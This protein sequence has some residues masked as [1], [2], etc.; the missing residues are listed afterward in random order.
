M[1]YLIRQGNAIKL[2]G[3]SDL[4]VEN[5]AALH[6][7]RPRSER[8]SASL[9]D[10]TETGGDATEDNIISG[11][12]MRAIQGATFGFGD[13]ALGS[14]LGVLT[15]EGAAGGIDSYRERLR[16][17]PAG[18]KLGL[19]AEVTGGFLTGGALVRGAAA[20]GAGS[21]TA[22]ST[23]GQRA[24][25]VGAQGALGGALGGAG[26]NEGTISERTKSALLGAG[27][28][29]VLGAGLVGAGRVAGSLLRAPTRAVLDRFK[30][31]QSALPGLGSSRDHARRLVLETIESEGLAVGQMRQAAAMLRTQGVAPTLADVGGEGTLQLMSE[32]LATRSPEKQKLAEA[33]LGR[34]SEQ[35]ARLSGD[36]FRR[37][38]RS[39]K[40]GLG[41]A[42]DTVDELA[43][44]R[45]ASAAPLYEQAYQ[46][47][48]PV[49]ERMQAIITKNPKFR[50]AWEEGMRIAKTEELAGVGHGLEI[51]QLP[52]GSLHEAARQKLIDI[53]ASEEAIT[54]TLAQLPND[55]PAQ[56]PVRGLDYMKRGIDVIINRG[57]RAN[58]LDNQEVRALRALREEMLSEVDAAVPAFAQARAVW[59]GYSQ[60]SEAVELGQQF[61]RK[62]GPL[63]AREISALAS[64]S[65]GLT[66]FYRLGA[67]QSLYETATGAAARSEKADVARRLFGGRLFAA[68]NQDAQRIRALFPDAPEVAEDFMRKVAAEARISHT[69]RAASRSG[70][71]R[72][73]Q[74]FEEAVEGTPPRGAMTPGLAIYSM[75][76]EGI[77]RA[78]RNFKMDVSDDIATL[79]SRGIDDPRELDLM[80]DALEYQQTQTLL[81]RKAGRIAQGAG[82][83]TIGSL[84]GK[85]F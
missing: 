28:G 40:P 11:L 32:T 12:S 21:L 63:V 46:V 14:L 7:A 3:G 27:A 9:A 38:F 68:D 8:V 48:V 55:F 35:G 36:L 18:G 4:D 80:F 5:F 83:A 71:G 59:G 20:A 30:N 37:I 81:R 73:L 69:A 2:N 61:L 6:A 54:A 24:M 60:A 34:Q 33:I 17:A 66:D 23:L 65:P 15:G 62:P 42:Y 82:A 72:S 43:R 29:A 74:Q 64:K 45:S 75:L 19:L 57:L 47:Q 13:E 31:L 22:A 51:P 1:S 78:G 58:A 84:A 44:I 41:N 56:L 70:T 52:S 10:M 49:T 76:R 50:A 16:S 67:A 25:A 85:I 26:H 77:I 79:F 39:N 53:G